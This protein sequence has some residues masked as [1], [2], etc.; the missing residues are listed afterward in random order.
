MAGST[1][2][3]VGFKKA[4]VWGEAVP[5]GAGD[6][7]KIASESF[8]S[9]VPEPIKDE[10]VGD[11]LTG[12]TWQGNV[13]LEGNIVEPVR[14]E[15]FGKRLGLFMGADVVSDIGV[16]AKVHTMAFKPSN[17]GLFGTLAIDKGLGATAARLWEYP[18]VKLSS[19]E[20]NHDGGRLV[21]TWGAMANLC[22]RDAAEQAAHDFANL[23]YPTTGLLAIFNQ[24]TV[25]IKEV[26]GAE[27]NLAAGDEKFVN[28]ASFTANRNLSGDHVS[29]SRAGTIDEPE[30][31][32]LPEAQVKLTF[33]NF[34][35][36]LDDLIAEAIK[37]QGGGRPKK[38]KAVLEW[39]GTTI[40]GEAIPYSIRL[41][42]P[43]LTI[44]DAPVNASGPGAK[45]PVEITFDVTTPD[46]VGNGTDW[47][48][49]TPGGDPFRFVLTNLDADSAV[50]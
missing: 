45:V 7:I 25:S 48:W 34:V 16:A 4:D 5:V 33:P 32:G 1:A 43:S 9:G 12:Q 18:S 24:L 10:N 44:A 41:E 22:Q 8:G 39:K 37:R 38:F 35:S 49:V 31:D 13:A 17:T 21:A 11:S 28:A 46:A 26:T 23:S 29:G 30:T 19:L 14:Y 50:A 27:G 42:L 47:S 3:R 2:W 20:L 6:G 15:G 36:G 40:A